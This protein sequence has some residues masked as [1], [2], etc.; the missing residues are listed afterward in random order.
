[1]KGYDVMKLKKIIA[2]AAAFS[3]ITS[4]TVSAADSFFT[5]KQFSSQSEFL[6][7][8]DSSEEVYDFNCDDKINVFDY[9]MMKHISFSENHIQTV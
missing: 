6:L 3:L 7:G 1:M 5:E 4:L 9:L 8:A 2:A